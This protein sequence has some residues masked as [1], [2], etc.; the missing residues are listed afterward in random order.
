M[1]KH[2]NCQIKMVDSK[3]TAVTA[4]N[5]LFHCPS[6]DPHRTPEQLPIETSSTANLRSGKAPEQKWGPKEEA[7]PATSSLEL[8]VDHK[9]Q[10]RR[11]LYN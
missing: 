4:S 8:H 3:E 7:G 11:H 9:L 1:Q 6:M 2:P 5:I 10:Q